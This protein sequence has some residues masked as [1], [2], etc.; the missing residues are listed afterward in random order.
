MKKKMSL[1]QNVLQLEYERQT[2]QAKKKK[3]LTRNEKK[4]VDLVH[5]LL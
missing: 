1:V 2:G 5:I 3:N 4:K